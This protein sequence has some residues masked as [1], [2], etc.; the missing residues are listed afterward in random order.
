MLT[1][2]PLQGPLRTEA[3]ES[4]RSSS[5]GLGEALEA[6]SGLSMPHRLRA[7][8]R[9]VEC[10]ERLLSTALTGDTGAPG[11]SLPDLLG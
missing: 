7:W 4:D 9:L 6:E 1:S 3:P 2:G 10:P 5:W 8:G 11:P